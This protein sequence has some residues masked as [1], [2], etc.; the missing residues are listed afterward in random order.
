MNNKVTDLLTSRR[1]QPIMKGV[2][3]EKVHYC[4]TNNGK[5][6]WEIGY[7]KRLIY[8]GVLEEH[9]TPAY[10]LDDLLRALPKEICVGEEKYLLNLNHLRYEAQHWS[11]RDITNLASPK[12]K[13]YIDNLSPQA[14]ADLLLWLDEQGLLPKEVKR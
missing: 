2:E 7:R 4:V 1:L 5:V 8:N 3:T 12:F 14:A 11:C 10:D 13:E 9:L 6:T